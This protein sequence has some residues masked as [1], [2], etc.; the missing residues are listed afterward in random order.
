VDGAEH[1]VVGEEV[2]KAQVLGPFS[3]PPDGARVPAKL[4]L[5]VDDADLHRAARRL[6]R[7]LHRA[8]F[9]SC[10]CRCSRGSAMS[11]FRVS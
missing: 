6:L 10:C 4:G 8:F 7:G 1:V 2:V 3:D 11:P 5:R 9:Q